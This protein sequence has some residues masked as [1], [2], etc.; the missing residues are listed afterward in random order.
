MATFTITTSKNIDSL[1]GKTGGD[2]YNINGGTLTIDQH[3]R[4]G[5]NN[6]NSAAT[7]ATSMGS[8][9][10]SATLGGTVNIDARYVRMI[11][12]TGGSGTI[13]ALNTLITQGDASG[14]LMCVYS[15][16][17]AAPLVNGGTMP[18]TGWIMIKQWNSV[19]YA[20][21]A[22]A[23]VTAIASG[24]DIVGFI[25]IFGDDAATVN[26]NRL[27]SFNVL[28]EWYLVGTTNGTSNQTMQIPNNGTL[29]HI[30]GVFI[31][32]T[33]G[34][35]DYE[36]YPNAGVATTTGTDST[37]GKCVWIDNTGLVRIGNSGAATNGYTPV[38]GLK[39]VIGNVMLQCCT[40]AARNAE[41]IPNATIATRYDFTTTGGGVVAMDKCT[42]AWYLSFTQAYS[43]TLTNTI[44]IDSILLSECATYSTWSKVGVGNKPTTALVVS[45][46]TMTYDF[47]GGLFTDCVWNLASMAASGSYTATITDCS[48]FSFVRNTFRSSVAR[49]NA[50]TYSIFGTR[51]NNS[52][53]TDTTIVQAQANLVTCN[54]LVF[55][56]T[57][58]SE[59]VG[60]T[61][62]TT[63]AS[64]VW[65]LSTNTINCTFSGL[66]LPVTN[67]HPY[68]AILTVTTGC[69]NI[70]LRNIGTYASPLSLG[71]ANACGNVL[72]I[73]AS[74]A[75]SDIKL[76][77]IYVSNTRLNGLYYASATSP[78]NTTTRVTI[79]N[80]FSDYA[81]SADLNNI[82]NL[83]RK[84][85][86]GVPA[87]TAAVSVYGTHFF[88]CHT[89]TT[90]GMVA[91]IMNEP[92]SLTTSSVSLTNGS[93]FTSAGGLYM[94]NTGQTATFTTPYYI[95]GHTSFQNVAAVMAGGTVGDYRYE[96]SIDINNGN[97]FSAMTTSSYTA[98]Q[99]G[100]AL[101]AIS[102]INASLGFKLSIKV[103]TTTANTN[104][105]TSFYMLTNST[106]TTQAYV[107][108]LDTVTLTITGVISGSDIVV[109]QAGTGNIRL[110]VDS[111]VG[112]QQS[113]T[114]ETVEN[115]DI[116][117]FK[118]G[119][120]PFYIRNYTLTTNN[121]SIPA[122]QIVDRAYL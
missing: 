89:S 92:T 77:R 84:G 101:N 32:K 57:T 50:T 117:I 63:Y 20:A 46:L 85:I 119:Y 12:F 36:F 73:P 83:T 44:A 99:L 34:S 115:I 1:T 74:A 122:A 38:T 53:W 3:S 52:T 97:G 45:P 87:L 70:K 108:P 22:V 28:G 8:I 64:Y 78:D 67:T 66:L 51:V 19:A 102:T 4:F 71:S 94:P 37:R 25:E 96:Y 55:S 118:A 5:L 29:K 88:D 60:T 13:P 39:V 103:T 93:K 69:A 49:G 61:T 30:G 54:N 111:L 40:T 80:C 76:Q 113:Y 58:F 10:L 26:A 48:N 41:V 109:Y 24:P 104:P 21:G 33:V 6:N 59:N 114:Y 110:S 98:A 65:S 7:T 90:A 116:G 82:L 95:I 106:T 47:A 35:N 18:S 121:S 107:Y 42:S 17:T 86:G 112:T 2:V 27:G 16:L 56:G 72:T 31:E 68:T 120:V 11:P 14:K 15:S 43:I 81:D 79:E 91:I 75:C 9:T 62:P 100:A 23:G 105:I